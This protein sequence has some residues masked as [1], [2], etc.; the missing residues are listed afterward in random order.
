MQL[1]CYCSYYSLFGRVLVV[2][3]SVC[4]S[5]LYFF[6]SVGRSVKVYGTH[7]TKWWSR[8][9]PSLSYRVV[10]TLVFM[11]MV[12]RVYVACVDCCCCCVVCCDCDS[13]GYIYINQFVWFAL[14]LSCPF[15]PSQL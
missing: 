7:E 4:F 2:C 10:L 8:P 1:V 3:Y 6:L 12:M 5:F 9:V 13:P 14:L 15:V 11:M